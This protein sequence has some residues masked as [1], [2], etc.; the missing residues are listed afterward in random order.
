[1]KRFKTLHVGCIKWNESKQDLKLCSGYFHEGPSLER[2]ES[3]GGMREE[4]E[5]EK[6]QDMTL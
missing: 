4:R 3:E 6:D 1:M 5:R 2:E